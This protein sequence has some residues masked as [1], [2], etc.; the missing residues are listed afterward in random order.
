MGRILPRVARAVRRTPRRSGWCETGPGQGAR[1]RSEVRGTVH[2]PG[3]W[4]QPRGKSS[5]RGHSNG[6][7]R[8]DE[9]R[10]LIRGHG[11]SL[12]CWRLRQPAVV[13]FESGVSCRPVAQL[14]RLA[15]EL[16]ARLKTRLLLQV[17]ALALVGRE[18]PGRLPR[19]RT[20]YVVNVW[21]Q[22]L[23]MVG[24]RPP[25]SDKSPTGKKQI[26]TKICHPAKPPCVVSFPH[27]GQ[28]MSAMTP[29][30]QTVL[31][32]IRHSQTTTSAIVRA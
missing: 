5:A 18:F 11:P 27:F 9:G 25:R 24:L 3:A 17:D 10:A 28:E 31:R 13:L 7:H 19:A 1:R 12:R 2:R 14:S 21:L 20:C 15:P 4:R 29:P 26:E 16:L 22:L 32:N 23:Q 8:E 6:E 30:V